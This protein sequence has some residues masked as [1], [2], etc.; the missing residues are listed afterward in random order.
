MYSPGT[1]R[2]RISEERVKEAEEFID[3][4]IPTISGRDYKVLSIS[5]NNLYEKYCKEVPDPFG[6]TLFYSKVLNTFKIHHNKKV[7]FCPYC[8]GSDFNAEKGHGDGLK[9]HQEDAEAQIRYYFRDKTKVSQN[10]DFLLLVQDF[11]QIQ[12]GDDSCQDLIITIYYHD[13][14]KSCKIGH[15][16]YHFLCEHPNDINFVASAWTSFIDEIIER[17]HPTEISIWSDRGP[18]HFKI[19]K[20]M[21][22]WWQ[23]STT[24]NLQIAYNF[25]ASYHGHNVCDA[26][27][28]HVKRAVTKC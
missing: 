15:E 9:Q 8:S 21:A 6:K 24:L 11:T 17:F 28:A 10:H 27:A 25:F 4:N 19:S 20:H 13:D 3:S 5:H 23:T 1:K 2:K 7:D 18:K 26:A 12:F 16:F 14:E 22:F